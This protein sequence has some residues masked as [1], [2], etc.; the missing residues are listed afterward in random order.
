[1][2]KVT[3]IRKNEKVFNIPAELKAGK[4]NLTP[5][6]IAVLEKNNNSSEFSSWENVFV[7]VQDDDFDCSLIRNSRFEG[8]VVIG[9][10]KYAKLKYHSLE[11]ETGIVNSLVRDS[12]IG[13]DKPN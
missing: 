12:V 3:F 1:M 9:R 8:Y 10:L 2:P 7:P 13:D 11:L 6:E 5:Q 4:R